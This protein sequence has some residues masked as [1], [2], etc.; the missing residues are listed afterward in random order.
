M[1]KYRMCPGQQP[2]LVQ[3]ERV[4]EEGQNEQQLA[5]SPWPRGGGLFGR[6]PQND[7]MPSQF[8][9]TDP[10]LMMQRM[11]AMLGSIFG[12]PMY[13]PPHGS[14]GQSPRRQQPPSQEAPPQQA[15]SQQPMQP[16]PR[17]RVY[18]A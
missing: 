3:E 14:W 2:V 11:D 18:E 1:R 16:P 5:P 8:G 15:P 13:G 10:F 17:V 7:A 4:Q 12:G 6:D 9:M